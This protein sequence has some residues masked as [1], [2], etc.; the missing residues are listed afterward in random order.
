MGLMMVSTRKTAV[1]SRFQGTFA[2]VCPCSP[3]FTLVELLLVVAVI[4]VLA[5]L[6]LP[7]LARARASA[8]AVSCLNN[9]RQ[10]T[11]GWLLYA[12]Q[13]NDHLVYNLGLDKRQPVPPANRDLNWVNNVMS[14]ELDSDNTN[15]A[16]VA[17]SPLSSFIGRS[18]GV[19]LCPSDQVVSPVQRAAGWTRR[20]RSFSMNAMV[21]DA[22]PNVQAGSN[23]L[24]PGYRQYLR[25]SDISSPT[26]IF[27]ILDEHPDSIGDGY[28]YNTIYD[29]EWVHLP[30]SYH[31]GAANFSF[32]DGHAEPH[33]WQSG[34]IK[35]PAR[36]DVT[37][38]PQA[39]TPADLVDYY[40][41]A[42]RSSTRQ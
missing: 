8:A 31:S 38:L 22:G 1:R 4:A 35:P 17:K 30:A 40:W 34:R 15:L 21:G 33:K 37:S 11:L 36:P 25:L 13:S 19:F 26:S 10:L 27:V 12:D 28:F 32:A 39:V 18:P 3:A 2:R 16:F 6:L 14:W 23:I 42:Y 29:R 20:V 7:V 5:G 24:N 41:V 9:T